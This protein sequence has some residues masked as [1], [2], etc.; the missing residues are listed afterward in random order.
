[1]S[2]EV[3]TI[4]SHCFFRSNR[5]IISEYI[6][7]SEP[8]QTALVAASLSDVNN[9]AEQA[10]TTSHCVILSFFPKGKSI[11]S[12]YMQWNHLPAKNDPPF[13][14][15]PCIKAVSIFEVFVFF[16]HF[17]QA[18]PFLAINRW[19]L[20]SVQ[21]LITFISFQGNYHNLSCLSIAL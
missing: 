15:I 13:L 6:P 8:P 18:L 1:M 5:V 16:G 3:Q 17:A 20:I 9:Y 12:C 21:L 7:S 10:L 14:N 19:F 4:S 2:N 11:H